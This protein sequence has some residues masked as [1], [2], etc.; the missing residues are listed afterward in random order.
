MADASCEVIEETRWG[1]HRLV[2]A[3]DPV[4]AQ[5]QSAQ[6][7]GKI[8]A[9]HARAAELA[10][11]LDAQ[12]DGLVR[13]GRKLSDSGAK[14]RFFHEV[15]D[16]HLSRIIKGDLQSDVFT[17]AVDTQ[18]LQRAALMDGKLM[19]VTNVADL[20]ATEVVPCRSQAQRSMITHVSLFRL[21]GLSG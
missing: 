1:E 11:K 7:Q 12:D 9:L 17:Y 3:H 8:D 15:S 6:R 18:A 21:L 10:G 16:A 20:S 4:N 5:E 13:R 19:L 2:I 14:A